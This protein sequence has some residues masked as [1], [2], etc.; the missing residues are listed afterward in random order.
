MVGRGA[1]GAPWMPARIDATLSSGRDPGSPPLAEQ[2]AIARRHVE[3]MLAEHGPEHGLRIARKHVGWYLASSGRPADAVAAGRR[4]RARRR[5]PA[6][7]WTDWPCSTT[8]PTGPKR[9]RWPHE[10]RGTRSPGGTS[11]RRHIEHDLLLAALPHPVL[12]L[13][14]DDRVLYANLAAETFFSLSHGMLKRQTLP[15][16]IAFA[17]P[18]ARWWGRCASRAPPS[19]S[20]ASR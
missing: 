17:S 4:R 3:A 7:C 13:G 11:Q 15:D 1:Y 10:R 2:G 5:M 18:L 19:T 20:T 8:K 16:I 9:G 14:D 12:V 6:R